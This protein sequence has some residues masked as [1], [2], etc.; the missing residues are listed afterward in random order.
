[1]NSVWF[2]TLRGNRVNFEMKLLLIR[3]NDGSLTSDHSDP[4]SL[5]IIQSNIEIISI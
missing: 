4:I 2:R 5:S 1:M 3:E